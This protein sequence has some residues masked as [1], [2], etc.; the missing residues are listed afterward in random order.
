MIRD[1][2]LFKT[3]LDFIEKHLWYRQRFDACPHFM[4][5]LGDSHTSS[6]QHTKYP[7]GQKIAYAGFSRNR[8]DW[9]HRLEEREYTASQIVAA[10]KTRPHISAEM[11]K[12]FLPWQETFYDK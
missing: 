12:D 4:F 8:A 5:F 9:Y 11:I 7:F 10:S 6:I 3:N 2:N 1:P